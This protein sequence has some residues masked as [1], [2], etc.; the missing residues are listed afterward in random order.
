MKQQTNRLKCGLKLKK[1]KNI[2][3]FVAL[4]LICWQP[5]DL[6]K[7]YIHCVDACLLCSSAGPFLSV[8]RF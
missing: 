5:F 7:F 6:P 2:F 4:Q 3:T 8:L 1:Q